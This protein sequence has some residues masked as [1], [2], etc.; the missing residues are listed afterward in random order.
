M[1][2]EYGE[3]LMKRN[4]QKGSAL[5][6]AL[7]L[8]LVL[9]AMAGSLMFLSRSETFSSM[10]YRMMTQARYGAEAGVNAAA[11]FIMN[12]YVPPVATATPP[13]TN[14]NGFNTGTYPVTDTAG[15]PIFLSTLSTQAANYPG[16]QAQTAFAN[17][18]NANQPLQAGANTV[19]YSASAQLMSMI[20]VTPFGTTT[21]VTVQ[22][23]QITSHGDIANVR[24]AEAEVV[25]TLERY[26]S[27]AFGYAAFADG[28]GCGQLSFTGN[29]TT[30]SYDSAAL[31]PNGGTIVPNSSGS[32]IPLNNFGGNVGTNGN[33]S[34]SGSS[35]TINGSLST[36]N[37][38][39]GVCSGGNVTALS[40]GSLNQ[41]TGGLVQLPQA[42]TFPTPVTYPPGATNISLSGNNTQAIGP[43]TASCLANPCSYGDIN[44]TAGAPGLTLYPGTYNINSLS[45]SG[46]GQIT[47]AP[48]PVTGQYGPIVINVAGINN[49]TP[50]VL[51]GN[52]LSNPTYNPSL[53]QFTYA[54]N[55]TITIAGNGASAAVVY[56]PNATADMKGNATFYGSVIAKQL[57][58]VGNGAI[59]YDMHLQKSLFT[60][61]NYVLNSFTWNKY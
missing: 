28:S 29:G 33:E 16:G 43:G 60:I 46:N 45:V 6:F 15:N 2:T 32:N 19:N 12:T 27:P 36:P 11:N 38:G 20:S 7:I 59:Y 18:M 49:N 39:F 31:T 58:D 44:V 48:D 13:G 5:I 52:A 4:N 22:T 23:W 21:P 8:L 50:I 25:T 41:V 56:A 30:N 53:V 47:I 61:G 55:G 14:F 9:S 24:N 54:G 37:A 42:V 26:I 35:V 57:T 3:M 17:A 10:N 1:K 34:D 51:T 40:G